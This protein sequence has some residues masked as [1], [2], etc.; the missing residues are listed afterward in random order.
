MTN[1]QPEQIPNPNKA[2]RPKGSRNRRTI[3]REALQ[4]AYPDGE[5]GFWQAVAQQAADG[6]LQAAAMIADRL[7]PKLKPT[8]EPVALSEPLDGSPG[9]VARAIMR[10]AGAGELTTDQAKELLSALADVCKIVE[11]TE[12]EQRIEKLEKLEETRK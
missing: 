8:S 12:L 11:V 2:G 7:Y 9:D 1:K 6:D 10:M 5:L 4:Q 3:A